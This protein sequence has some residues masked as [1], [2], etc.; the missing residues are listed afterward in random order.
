[1][2]IRD[3]FLAGVGTLA[4]VVAEEDSDGVDGESPEEGVTLEASDGSWD[5]EVL[6][7]L[8]VGNGALQAVILPL[9]LGNLQGKLSRSWKW[10]GFTFIIQRKQVSLLGWA[11]LLI[12]EEKVC[13]QARRAAGPR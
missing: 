11:D 9:S 7:L 5:G 3:E 1:M 8:L 13:M 6:Q 12:L 4:L 2:D 10:S